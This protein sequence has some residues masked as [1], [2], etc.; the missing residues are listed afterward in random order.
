MCTA[1]SSVDSK[2]VA[3]Q[4]KQGCASNSKNNVLTFS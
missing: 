3:S 2:E 1:D 4:L